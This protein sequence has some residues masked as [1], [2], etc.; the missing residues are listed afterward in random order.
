MIA[1]LSR[2][3][4]GQPSCCLG[5]DDRS[6]DNQDLLASYMFFLPA[7]DMYPKPV[8]SQWKL[9]EKINIQK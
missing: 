3:L 4:F 8:L 5:T 7:S 2:A 6:L 1:P 9:L